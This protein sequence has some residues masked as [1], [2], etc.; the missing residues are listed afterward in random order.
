MN[1]QKHGCEFRVVLFDHKLLRDQLVTQ[2]VMSGLTTLT[3]S[4][5][6]LRLI[7]STFSEQSQDLSK[8]QIRALRAR[9]SAYLSGRSGIKISSSGFSFGIGV[10]KKSDK[11]QVILGFYSKFLLWFL[12]W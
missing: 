3:Y 5:R 9:V 1:D 12:G 7:V 8:C 6:Q 11:N 10:P 2:D 4:L